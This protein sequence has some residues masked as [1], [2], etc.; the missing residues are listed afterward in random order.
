[1]SEDGFVDL[2][3]VLQISQNADAETLERVFRLLAKRYHPDNPHSG[4]EEKFREVHTAYRI[5]SDAEQRARFDA[6]YDR[7]RSAQWQIFGQGTAL[8]SQADDQKI[9]D[10]VLTLLYIARR[11]N[12]ERGGL[13]TLQL[14]KML[15]VPREHLEFPLWVLRKRGWI[16]ILDSGQAAITIDGI[17]K[18]I[19]E[20]LR[21][22]DD[23]LITEF[24][25]KR[26]WEVE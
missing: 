6:Q 22:T 20:G 18:V 23:R 17:D 13:G 9:I 16:E 21:P 4:D 19:G 8:G 24:A 2:Y 5:L 10:C 7:H 1:M 25:T 15:G 14:E 11:R 3:E 26:E 12:P